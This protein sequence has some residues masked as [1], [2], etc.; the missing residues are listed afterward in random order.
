MDPEIVTCP[1]TLSGGDLDMPV[2]TMGG[3]VEVPHGTLEDRKT[4]AP[5]WPLEVPAEAAEE[6][7]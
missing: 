6:P 1:A 5:R 7:H 3:T 2:R 4:E